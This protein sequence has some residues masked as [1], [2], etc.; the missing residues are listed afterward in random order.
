M[1]TIE[2]RYVKKLLLPLLLFATIFVLGINIYLLFFSAEYK[3]NKMVQI[4][5]LAGFILFVY[6]LFGTWKKILSKKPILVFTDKE[7]KFQENKDFVCISWNE[8]T[9]WR[10]EKAESD[11]GYQLLIETATRKKKTSLNWLNKPPQEIE[12]LMKIYS[13]SQT[14][15]PGVC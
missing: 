5:Q 14:Y 10:V 4:I 13:K 9:Y 12:R 7:L 6:F 3:D 2:V 15:E 11:S 1:Q 8:I